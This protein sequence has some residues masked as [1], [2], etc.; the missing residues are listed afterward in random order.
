MGE[1]LFCEGIQST[2][3]VC[4]AVFVVFD[5]SCGNTK[6]PYTALAIK[7]NGKTLVETSEVADFGV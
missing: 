6:L 2:F 3:K 1:S 5:V 4:V 7:K